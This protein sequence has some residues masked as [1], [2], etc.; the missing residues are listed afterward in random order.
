MIKLRD[1][2]V[3]SA[4]ELCYALKQEKGTTV[5]KKTGET[6]IVYSIPKYYATI[7]QCANSLCRIL[8]RRAVSE[9][10]FSPAE[11][12][13]ALNG[14]REDVQTMFSEIDKASL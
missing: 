14:I 5:N 2:W 8:Q 1:G 3:I 12:R 4:D 13:T 6:E 11:A 7:E 9:R 10:D